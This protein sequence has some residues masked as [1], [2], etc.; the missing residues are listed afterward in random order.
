MK[1]KENVNICWYYA[2]G[3]C[4]FGSDKCWF[5]HMD[6]SETKFEC[7]KC[8]KTFANKDTFSHHR[9]KNH[10]ESVKTCKNVVSGACRYGNKKC[11]FN[12]DDLENSTKD[13]NTKK[14]DVEVIEKL[15][16]MM[17]KFTLQMVE[18]KE[19]NNLK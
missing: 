11:W 10:K 15:F 4:E 6:G 18:M 3:Y 1:H 7:N 19:M 13:E 12:H 2:S 17:E 16:H 9:K 14:I 5:L 8:E